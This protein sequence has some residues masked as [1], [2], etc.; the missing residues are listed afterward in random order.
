MKS[1]QSKLVLGI[2]LGLLF[3]QIR[4]PSLCY[5]AVF[6]DLDQHW[7][8]PVIEKL[9]KRSLLTGYPDGQFHPGKAISRAEFAVII[10]R[11]IPAYAVSSPSPHQPE[12]S[13]IS[14]ADWFHDD[15]L[16]LAMLGI[17]CGTGEDFFQPHKPV[18]RQEAA[19]MV[20]NWM[21]LEGWLLEHE[22][23]GKSAFTDEKDISNWAQ[24]AVTL[25]NKQNILCGYPDSSFR[26]VQPLSRAEAALLVYKVMLRLDNDLTLPAQALKP[27]E[28]TQM[29]F[30]YSRGSSGTDRPSPFTPEDPTVQTSNHLQ[31]QVRVLN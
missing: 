25:L 9:A 10:A 23:D 1:M 26:P 7:A 15:V 28:A 5:A 16:K 27:D 4:A 22:D 2:L 12:F 31:C 17:I 6:P 11:T 8:Q 21:C 19:Q 20:L 29:F 30:P 13:D 14:A 18:Q 24:K 3:G